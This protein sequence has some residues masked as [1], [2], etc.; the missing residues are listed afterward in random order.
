MRW[1]SMRPS[2]NV[3]DLSALGRKYTPFSPKVVQQGFDERDATNP[4]WQANRRNSSYEMVKGFAQ[5]HEAEEFARAQQINASIGAPGAP[6]PEAMATYQ[7]SATAPP[8]V[9]MPVAPETAA[10]SQG[11]YQPP[12]MD[13][14]RYLQQLYGGR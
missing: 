13:I 1:Q 12:S 5:A 11:M 4:E 6:S 2:E 10:I 7:G 14:M 9:N 3:V 8:P